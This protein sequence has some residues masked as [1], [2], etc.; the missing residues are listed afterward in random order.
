[1]SEFRKVTAVIVTYQSHETIGHTLDAFCPAFDAGYASCVVVDNASSDGTADYVAEQYPWVKLVRSPENLGF[2]RGCNLGFKSVE[3]PYLLL[4][5]PDASI[6]LAGLEVLVDFIDSHPDVGIVGPATKIIGWGY[7]SA[8]MLLTPMRLIRASLGFSVMHKDERVIEPGG[9]SFQT[10]WICGAVFMI[11]SSLFRE[12][13][14]FDPRFFL[15]FEETDLSLRTLRKGMEIWAV[16]E[17]LSE[18]LAGFSARRSGEVMTGDTIGSTVN[19]HYYES[20]YYYMGKNFG[21]FSAIAAE[22][23]SAVMDW[24]RWQRKKFRNCGEGQRLRP[25]KRPIMKLPARSSSR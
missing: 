4:L 17:A 13:D 12:L 22:L 16:G 3:T 23:V 1:M 20:R 25:P 9:E 5:N 7:Q 14:G 2:G 10:N 8:G 15:Y 21:W 18:H 19:Q 11:R 6:S 24:V